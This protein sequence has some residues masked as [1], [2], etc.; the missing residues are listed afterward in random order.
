[1]L[2]ACACAVSNAQNKKN[3]GDQ[4]PESPNA[5]SNV[6]APAPP[7]TDKLAA[8]PPAKSGTSDSGSPQVDANERIARY[9]GVLAILAVFQFLTMGAQFWAM[10]RQQT[11]MR[12]GLGISIRSARAATHSA[13][14]AKRSAEATQIAAASARR[15]AD[16]IINAERA[17]LMVEL[18]TSLGSEGY[19][20]GD[21][22]ARIRLTFRNDGSTPA[23]V[24][25]VRSAAVV[26]ERGSAPLD[27]DSAGVVFTGPLPVGVNKQEIIDPTAVDIDGVL[28]L[29]ECV[30]VY[31]IVAYRH[32]FGTGATTFAYTSSGG[33]WKRLE[34]YPEYNNNT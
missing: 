4:K 19:K 25:N 22:Y 16:T 20:F 30:I 31:G 10:H 24:D 28:G 27:I 17:W 6:S 5:V 13:Q 29:G 23:W 3:V 18:A 1:M 32:P 33:P 11:Y 26:V 9:T 14:A 12:K 34:G 8:S 2:L 7:T 15:S 21:S